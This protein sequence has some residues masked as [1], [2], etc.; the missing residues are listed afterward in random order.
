MRGGGGSINHGVVGLCG[1][2]ALRGG[3]GTL[4]GGEGAGTDTPWWGGMAP[5]G[6]FIPPPPSVA[7]GDTANPGL[8]VRRWHRRLLG[9]S[10]GRTGGGEGGG[11][12]SVPFGCWGG[13][14]DT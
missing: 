6:L 2:S 10:L 14:G 13:G 1:G 8:S 9:V 12:G 5:H 7:M 4:G 11:D 3:A